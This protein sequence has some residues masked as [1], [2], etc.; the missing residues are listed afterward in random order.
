MEAAPSP[1]AEWAWPRCS[2]KC[3]CSYPLYAERYELPGA[4]GRPVPLGRLRCPARRTDWFV[5]VRGPS[6]APSRAP[7]SILPAPHAPPC[8]PFAGMLTFLCSDRRVPLRGENPTLENLAGRAWPGCRE[9][10][11]RGREKQRRVGDRT[12]QGERYRMRR[13]DGHSCSAGEPGNYLRHGEGERIGGVA[14]R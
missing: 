3:R 2:Y 13:L 1:S 6:N 8:P 12:G 7:E 14:W 10:K 9:L 5:R 4:I 11:R